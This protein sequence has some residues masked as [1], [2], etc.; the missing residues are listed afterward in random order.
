MLKTYRT[1]RF[2]RNVLDVT[3][4]PLCDAVKKPI[5][6]RKTQTRI[7]FDDLLS[8]CRLG[9][10]ATELDPRKLDGLPEISD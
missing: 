1:S 2:S 4:Q 8:F 3:A 5:I 10:N 7:N 9:G 6:R